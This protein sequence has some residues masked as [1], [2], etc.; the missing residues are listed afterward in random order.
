MAAGYVPSRY[1]RAAV[2]AAARNFHL[3]DTSVRKNLNLFSTALTGAFGSVGLAVMENIPVLTNLYHT[4][5]IISKGIYR[6]CPSVKSYISI[7]NNCSAKHIAFRRTIAD[8]IAQFM[9]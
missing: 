4:T 1:K 6:I 2:E 8:G 3:S 7:G 9:T 5:V